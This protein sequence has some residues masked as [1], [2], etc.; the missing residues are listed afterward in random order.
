MQDA[1]PPYDRVI[2][3]HQAVKRWVR[4]R[5]GRP[6]IRDDTRTE[7]LAIEFPGEDAGELVRI[8]WAEFFAH[9]EMQGLALA[10]DDDAGPEASEVGYALVDR[11][12]DDLGT[13]ESESS[14]ASG[15]KARQRDEP[16]DRD[17]EDEQQ[18]EKRYREAASEANADA[19]RDEPP[20]QS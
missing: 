7:R 11:E 16:P 6:A 12:R 15:P 2:S 18:A 1:D 13:S 4:Q 20:F 19:H 17:H 10:C 5:G 14:S 8:D 3:D 9:F